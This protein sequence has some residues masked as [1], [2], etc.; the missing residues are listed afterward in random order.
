MTFSELCKQKKIHPSQ[1]IKELQEF[2]QEGYLQGIKDKN[3]NYDYSIN[4]QKTVDRLLKLFEYTFNPVGLEKLN[5]CLDN[6]DQF[7]KE[8]NI[9]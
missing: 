3:P 6:M 1:N 5:L 7:K 4:Y 9:L 8:N 2:Y